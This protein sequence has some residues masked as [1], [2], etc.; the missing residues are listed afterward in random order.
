MATPA[1]EAASFVAK[2]NEIIL[3]PTIALLSG[4]AFLVFIWGCVEYFMHA[5]NDQARSKGAT[6]ITFGIIGL[7]VMLSAWAIL[8]I[9]ANTFGL[10]TQLNC[11]DNPSGAGC[12]AAF[13]VP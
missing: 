2:F 5:E 12:D 1:G 13:S 6:H 7:V 9:A 8:T 11:A 4:V 10:G 3:F